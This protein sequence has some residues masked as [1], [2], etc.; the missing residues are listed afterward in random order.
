[1][2]K[3]AFDFNEILSSEKS[4]NAPHSRTIVFAA[5]KFKE[6]SCKKILDLACG[7]GRDSKYLIQQG[8][9]VTGV[10]MSSD[11]IMRLQNSYGNNFMVADALHLPFEDASFD[12]LYNF[13]LLHVFTDNMEENRTKLM[14][15]INRVLKPGGIA[16]I[17]TLWTDIPGCGLPKLC[18]ITAE[19][20]EEI[21]RPFNALDKEVVKDDSCTGWDSIHWRIVIKREG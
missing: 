19:E 18:C 14:N 21:F 13:G 8:F 3:E 10:D 15:E 11:A 2:S 20:I 1:M 6:H 16:I 17:T 12:G 9:D 4:L 7:N 5:E